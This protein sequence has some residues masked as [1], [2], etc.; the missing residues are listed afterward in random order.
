MD[1]WRWERWMEWMDYG[2]ARPSSLSTR[3]KIDSTS[4]SGQEQQQG[5][6]TSGTQLGP[7]V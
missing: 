6:S 2:A 7:L 3:S 5:D 1:G 4:G